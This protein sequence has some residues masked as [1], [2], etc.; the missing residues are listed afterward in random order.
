MET[1]RGSTKLHCLENL[2]WKRLWISCKTDDMM[3]M[4]IC[5]TWENFLA[6]RLSGSVLRAWRWYCI[7]LLTI[8]TAGEGS[9]QR[10]PWVA[11]TSWLSKANLSSVFHSPS[12]VNKLM[13]HR[14]L[15]KAEGQIIQCIW[16][17]LRT[18]K[19]CWKWCPRASIQAW[20]RLLCY[21]VWEEV[22]FFL[23][24]FMHCYKPDIFLLHQLA[25]LRYWQPNLRTVTQVHSDFLNALYLSLHKKCILQR[26]CQSVHVKLPHGFRYKPCEQ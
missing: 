2:L 15:C 24:R 20:T 3:M 1:E 4:M 18:Y 7:W 25:Q 19:R 17:S 16:K 21:F 14:I 5:I 6:Q 13:S 12:A 23:D 10:G 22:Q 26:L 8:E 11:R 9:R